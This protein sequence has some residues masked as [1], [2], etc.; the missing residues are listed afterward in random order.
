LSPTKVT[1]GQPLMKNA[2]LWRQHFL[3]PGFVFS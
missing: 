1:R 3:S 2:K